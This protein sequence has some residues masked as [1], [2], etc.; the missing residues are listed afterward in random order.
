MG[1]GSKEASVNA[2]MHNGG[3]ERGVYAGRTK[4]SPALF[5]SRIAIGAAL[6]AAHVFSSSSA[7]AQEV[8]DET[9]PA[10]EAAQADTPSGSEIIVTA[11]KRN[12]R[13]SD[14]PMSITAVSGEQL[15]EKGINSAA[16]LEKV[17]PGLTY[18]LS[19]NGTPVFS[20]RG[21]GF[22]SE[23][24]A[25]APTVTI[26]TDQIPLPYARMS[27]GAAL[28]VERVEILKGPQGTLFG[29]NATGGAVN[30]IAAK[31]TSHLTGGAG[32]TFGR[33]NQVDVNGFVSGP[34]SDT[35]QAR[36][37]VRYEQRDNWQT[38]R[39]RDDGLGQHDFLVG[40]LLLDW[41]PDDRLSV[42]INV[43]GWRDRSDTQ[44][45]Q[46]RGY[47]PLVPTP[48]FTPQAAATAAALTTYP[49]LSGNSNRVSDWDPGSSY[50][51]NDRF[52]QA[53]ANVRYRFSDDLSLVSISSYADL[54]TFAP[55]D[56]DGTYYTA[57]FLTQRSAITTFNQELRLEGKA[58]AVQWVVGA[59]YQRDDTSEQL[60]HLI[61]GANAQIPSF[62]PGGLVWNSFGS[63]ILYNDQ[64]VESWA[65]FGNV[66]FRLT[67]SITFQA[68]IRYTDE[69]RDFA[70]CIADS[71]APDSY[72]KIAGLPPAGPRNCVT[73]LPSGAPG[74]YTSALDQNNV[75][76]RLSANWKP[77]RDILFY[78]NATKGYKSGTFGTLPALSFE[79]FQPVTQESV[80]AYEFGTKLSLFDRK[81]DFSL[82]G[83]YDAYRNKQTQG[84]LIV[85]PFG[86]LPYLVNIPKSEIYGVEWEATVRPVQGLRVSVA[87]TYLQSKV[88]GRALVASPFGDLVDVAGEGLPVTPKWQV[89]ADAE[90]EFN[91]FDRRTAFVGLALSART[92]SVAQLGSKS[93]PVGTQDYFGIDGYALLDLRAGVELTDNLRVQVF[94]KNVTGKGYWNNV[95][96][97]Y[98]TYA[99]ITGQPA[100]YGITLSGKF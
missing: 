5:V 4:I 41:S 10:A 35:L 49:Y 53:A 90:Y 57:L 46:A 86:P 85:P 61:R 44:V 71:A 50:R 82:A 88:L 29:Q 62:G 31:P 84:S 6:C 17:V 21:I 11:Q 97:I 80:L 36:L 100:T 74:E 63:H 52:F 92:K 7:A 23:Q 26:Y 56:S 48:P 65:G 99:R 60:A 51:R 98:D 75:S 64:N 43:N 67:D 2:I 16:D 69:N 54:D 68:G 38:N 77:A 13:L 22:Y 8:S 81:L 1:R 73:L 25:V 32:L 94:G 78:A 42:E 28:D 30:Y 9:R 40:R 79:Q 72:G 58:G 45:A 14:V 70:G 95:V 83:F 20:I 59:S 39:V 24:A 27:Q 47:L 37:A 18:R 15:T 91:I 55:I 76:W 96:H 66:D 19:Q 89:Q 93:G 33:F 12:E 87:G 34:I 3:D